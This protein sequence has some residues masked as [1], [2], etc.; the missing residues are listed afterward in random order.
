MELIQLHQ[1]G[2]IKQIGNLKINVKI[3]ILHDDLMRKGGAE[4]VAQYFVERDYDI[5]FYIGPEDFYEKKIILEYFPDAF[6]PEDLIKN[7]SGPEVV[8]ASTKFLV[9]SL[10]NDSGVSHMLST[11]LCP[12][13]KL[14]GQRDPEKFTP[15]SSKIKTISSKEYGNNDINSIT[16][17]EVIETIE[18]LL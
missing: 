18:K 17:K 1:S 11:N 6:F 7:F 15:R 3:A 8:M 5:A 13:L 14:F 2:I 4:R 10:S 12:L 9:F 16:I